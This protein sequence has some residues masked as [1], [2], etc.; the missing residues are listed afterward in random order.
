MKKRRQKQ[1]NNPSC[2]R[3]SA[4]PTHKLIGAYVRR[5][6]PELYALAWPVLPVKC[7]LH[8]KNSKIG[9]MVL[10]GTC[11]SLFLERQFRLT[12]INFDQSA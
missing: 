3:S 4:R 8:L 12:F 7:A 10:Y 6:C 9:I 1:R 2:D 11:F 5:D